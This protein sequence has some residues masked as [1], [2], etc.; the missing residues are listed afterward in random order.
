MFKLL[1][2]YMLRCSDGLYYVGVTNDINRRL[3]EHNE[4]T[5]FD[6]F[7]FKRRPVN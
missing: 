2:G 3:E 7:T 5:N 1:Y 4:G 6:S